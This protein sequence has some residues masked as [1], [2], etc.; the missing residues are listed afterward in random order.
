M[1]IARLGTEWLRL[2]SSISPR[3]VVC[4]LRVGSYI[5]F[6]CKD[7]GV[8]IYTSMF[9]LTDMSS[10]VPAGQTNQSSTLTDGLYTPYLTVVLPNATSVSALA[11]LR[12]T[13]RPS[14]SVAPVSPDEEDAYLHSHGQSTNNAAGFSLGGSI[15]LER[16]KFRIVFVLWP[17]LVGITMAL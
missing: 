15:D 17:A 8:S 2:V 14:P 1:D 6:N 7:R 10:V 11:P 5:R 9:T 3:F 16:L 4:R 13:A 12:T